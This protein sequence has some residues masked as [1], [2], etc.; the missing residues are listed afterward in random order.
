ML[1]PDHKPFLAAYE[2]DQMICRSC[3][4]ASST[5]DR[6]ALEL[7]QCF[8]CQAPI[9][10]PGRMGAL[11]L[12]QPLKINED[13]AAYFACHPELPY[14]DFVIKTVTDRAHAGNGSLERLRQEAMLLSVLGQH[15]AIAPIVEYNFDP[16]QPYLAMEIAPGIR[17]DTYVE[18]QGPLPDLDVITLAM[19]LGSAAAH[20]ANCGYLYVDFQPANILF[21]PFHGACLYNFTSCVKMGELSPVDD[22][23]G[24][25][26]YRSPEYFAELPEDA[27]SSIFSLGMLLYYVL[28]GEAY[29]TPD[30]I[31][32][33]RNPKKL[34]TVQVKNES[35]KI[36]R[37]ASPLAVPVEKM[38][39][40]RPGQRFQTF[41]ELECLFCDM[42]E[43][44]F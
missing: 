37:I 27:R 32:L 18:R 25:V 23:A 20:L 44:Q 11:L 14:V 28:V 1:K 3:R 30:E 5:Q 41:T 2:R 6:A 43:K 9:M 21:D 13:I 12:Y 35:S 15:D 22:A 17:L 4:K 42:F 40:R 39:N 36:K 31:S 7:T 34:Q 8:H 29:Y 33:L 24:P 38:L 10:V 16:S 19:H 26:P